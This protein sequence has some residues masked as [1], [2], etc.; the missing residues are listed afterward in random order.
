LGKGYDLVFGNPITNIVDPGFRYEVVAF[1]YKSE[2]TTEDGKFIIPDGISYSQVQS[3]SFSSTV[4]EFRGTQSYQNE[5]K[6]S[7]KIG[8]GY[9]GLVV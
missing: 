9:N 6:A 5:L 1:D 8:G 4:R 3:C 2:I 7:V